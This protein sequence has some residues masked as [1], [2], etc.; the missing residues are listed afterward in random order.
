[1]IKIGVIVA[2]GTEDIELV[3]PSDIW[4]RAGIIV[5]L[6]SIHKKK[7]VVLANGTKVSCQAVL[8]AE[9]LSKFNAIYLPGGAK[10]VEQ[11]NALNTPKLIRFLRANATNPKVKFLSICAATKVYGEMGMLKGV[12]ATCYPGYESSF[13]SSYVNQPVV[14]NKGFITAN[15]PGSAFDFALKVVSELV[16]PATAKK[17]AKN[18]LYKG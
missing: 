18:M 17:I 5:K 7:N 11:L 2:N 10:G 15:G 6:I 12:K 13:K 1:M 8:S 14:S 16:S 3:V 4:N 9:N